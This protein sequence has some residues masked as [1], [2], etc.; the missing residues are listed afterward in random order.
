MKNTLSITY[1]DIVKYLYI[2]YSSKKNSFDTDILLKR[3][4]NRKHF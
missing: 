2:Y 3:L 4:S 1:I